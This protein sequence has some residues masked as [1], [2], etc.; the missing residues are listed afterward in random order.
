MDTGP[1]ICNVP[2]GCTLGPNNG[3]KVY[4][5]RTKG[6]NLLH[7][8]EDAHDF[9]EDKM[10]AELK[11]RKMGTIDAYLKPT[12]KPADESCVRF[13]AGTDQPPSIL[14][15]DELHDMI[16]TMRK[17]P[18]YTPSRRRFQRALSRMSNDVKAKVKSQLINS[19][20]VSL[21]FD[22]WS[23]YAKSYLAVNAHAIKGDGQP[24]HYI[25]GLVE[26][27]DSHTSANIVAMMLALVR[28]YIPPE[29][30]VGITSD[31]ASNN[32]SKAFVNETKWMIKLLCAGHKGSN[33]SK[34][35]FAQHPEA[36]RLLDRS[37]RFVKLSRRSPLTWKLLSTQQKKKKPFISKRLPA[38]GET[39]F[40]GGYIVLSAISEHRDA[41]KLTQDQLK[42]DPKLKATWTLIKDHVLQDVDMDVLDELLPVLE[43]LN[44]FIV[45]VQDRRLLLSDMLRELWIL[46]DVL[47]S[48]AATN[49]YA[50]T[51]KNSLSG[52]FDGFFAPTSVYV[53][54]SALDVRSK[55]VTFL[56]PAFAHKTQSQAVLSSTGTLRVEADLR[57]TVWA[58]VKQEALAVYQAF[59]VPELSQTQQ[60]AT[61]A[62]VDKIHS[63][64]SAAQTREQS[65]NSFYGES[66][67]AATSSSPAVTPHEQGKADVEAE[68]S[69]FRK[70]P[71]LSRDEDP[72]QWWE[73]HA[74]S[75]P[76]LRTLAA[77]LFCLQATE[78]ENERD[79]SHTGE[80]LH[81]HQYPSIER[82]KDCFIFPSLTF[83]HPFF[84]PCMSCGF[85]RDR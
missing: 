21:S 44:N 67:Q 76:I 85:F 40:N 20:A 64:T 66:E 8:L 49:Q 63:D 13:V 18:S 54:C 28:E 83:C 78:V 37:K 12:L 6:D 24:D 59:F 73:S 77:R 16:E 34:A 5:G 30:V 69:N 51:L 25:L 65:L 2:T 52:Y 1:K 10:I 81:N 29:S 33:A 9:D 39:R 47:A 50:V 53:L 19:R 48:L 3:P 79:F 84:S 71:Q 35:I 56:S 41:I 36:K 74:V 75:F 57:D 42:K 4:L 26:F 11:S 55:H 43:P 68:I 31:S 82:C 80:D 27:N 22:I 58:Q 38:I 60:L 17:T 70:I 62:S 14:D 46:Q 23:K 15:S 7:H 45:A 61:P 72:F 32:R